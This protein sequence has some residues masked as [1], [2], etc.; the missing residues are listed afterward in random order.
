MIVDDYFTLVKAFKI[1]KSDLTRLLEKAQFEIGFEQKGVWC[2]F[3]VF[4]FFVSLESSSSFFFLFSPR[5]KW[6]HD[7][8][9]EDSFDALNLAFCLA[10][11]DKSR[12]S[13]YLGT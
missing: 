6:I 5:L 1:C 2:F 12:Y 10:R 13:L 3:F 8:T 4:R 9:S 11:K 7:W